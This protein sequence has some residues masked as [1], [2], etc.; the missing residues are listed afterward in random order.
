MLL[1]KQYQKEILNNV[2]HLPEEKLIELADFS[3]F[4]KEHYGISNMQNKK[5]VKLGGLWKGIKIS[6]NEIKKARKKI[7][8]K[9]NSKEIL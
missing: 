8:Q 9:F 5:I 6:E 3:R 2:K 7:W 4:L 1:P